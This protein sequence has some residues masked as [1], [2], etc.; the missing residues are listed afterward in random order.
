MMSAAVAAAAALSDA[1]GEINDIDGIK[2]GLGDGGEAP[3]SAGR[4]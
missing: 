1:A 4:R 2:R 3:T